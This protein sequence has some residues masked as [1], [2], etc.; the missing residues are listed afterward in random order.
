M[1]TALE[2]DNVIVATRQ[3]ALEKSVLLLCPTIGWWRGQYQLP[4]ASTETRTNGQAVDQDDVTTPRAKLMT[5]TYPLDRN[6]TPWKKRFQ[7]IES[8]L[9]ALKERYSV[10]FPIPGVRIVPKIRGQ[11]ML[12][13][14]YGMTLGRLERHIKKARDEYDYHRETKLLEIRDEAVRKLGEHA[15]PDTPVYDADKL[16][17]EQSIAYCLHEAASEF[18]LNWPDI[19][20]Q[21]SRKN[22]VFVHVESKIPYN[23]SFMKEKFYLDVVPIELAGGSAHMVDEECLAEHED[24]VR[25]ALRRRI[26]EAVES[27]VAAP[28]QQLADALTGLKD[29]IARDGR[30]STK[31]FAPVHAAIQKI[32]LFEFV[33]NDEL[34]AKMRQ[35]E[36]QLETTVPSSLN[37]ESAAASG[38]SAAI[39]SF[40]AEVENE[41]KRTADISTFGRQH[42]AITFK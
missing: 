41:T 22:N 40:M 31:S 13:E 30:V 25:E 27:M 23:G 34:L 4:R 7:A 17:D 12:N 9:S 42:R 35:L 15:T 21:I 19:R 11:E 29:L 18:C 20:E 8:R 2:E 6:G 14:L 39:D 36:R 33:A 26:D 3:E 32:R 1:T 37:N 28:R 24:V 5:D 16:P 10:P 38:F